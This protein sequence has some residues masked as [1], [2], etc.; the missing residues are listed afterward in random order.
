[1]EDMEKKNKKQ[2]KKPPIICRKFLTSN[3]KEGR[4]IVYNKKN[5]KQN[6]FQDLAKVYPK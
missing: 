5:S 4:H 3:S 1:M 6:Y 2:T